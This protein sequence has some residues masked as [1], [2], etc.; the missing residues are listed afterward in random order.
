[1]AFAD[2]CTKAIRSLFVL[3]VMSVLLVDLGGLELGE[4]VGRK[5]SQGWRICLFC[6]YHD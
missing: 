3:F 2:L 6:V 4:N 1:M 5:C